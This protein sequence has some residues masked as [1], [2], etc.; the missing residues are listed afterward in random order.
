MNRVT[1][2]Y[3]LMHLIFQLC[4]DYRVENFWQ[5]LYK[6]KCKWEK[7][8]GTTTTNKFVDKLDEKV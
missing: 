1:A 6:V 7:P 3:L 8:S 4:K 2:D 5:I